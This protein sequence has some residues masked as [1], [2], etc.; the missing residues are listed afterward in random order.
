M[1]A[2]GDGDVH[3]TAVGTAAEALE[4]LRTRP[5]DCLV[6]DLGLPDMGGLELLEQIKREIN[7]QGLRVVVYTARDLTPEE[8]VRLDEMAESTIVKDV[9]SLEHLVDKTTL[10][11]HRVEAGLRPETRKMLHQ[12]QLADPDL[13]GKTVLIVDDDVRNIFAL[14]SKLERWGLVVLR[15][16]NGR[17]ALELLDRTP[18][19]DLVLMDIMMPEMDGYETMRAIREREAFRSLPIVALT[20]KAMKEVRPK[21][22]EAGA[23]DYLAKPVGSE[24]LLSTLRVWL[25][26]HAGRVDALGD[27]EQSEIP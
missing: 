24:Q 8:K 9:R 4:A 20:A 27:L 22:L 26:R 3:T 11:L 21:C 16:E 7:P 13:A 17:Q 12:L 6:L 18:D 23:S 1:A 15:A 10:F 5:F 19:V 2:I 14:T 25:R